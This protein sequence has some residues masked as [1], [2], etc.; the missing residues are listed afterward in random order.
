MNRKEKRDGQRP[1][2][3]KKREKK[4]KAEGLTKGKKRKETEKPE[5]NLRSYSSSSHTTLKTNTQDFKHIN[6]LV[7][8]SL[9]IFLRIRAE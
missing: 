6:M 9:N 5:E 3:E 4:N 2:K 1:R 8:L 7:L